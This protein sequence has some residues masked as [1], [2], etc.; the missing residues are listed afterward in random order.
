MVL[1][2]RDR[3]K[4][5]LGRYTQSVAQVRK[6]RNRFDPDELAEIYIIHP[7]VVRGILSALDAHPDWDDEQVA[8]SIDFE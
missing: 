2:E 8:E 3:E 7:K 4:M 5:R 1:M 6:F